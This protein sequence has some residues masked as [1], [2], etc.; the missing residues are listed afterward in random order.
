MEILSK[1]AENQL[2]GAYSA[3]TFGFRHKFTFFAQTVPDIADYLL[4][5]EKKLKS[6]LPAITE[7][8]ICSDIERALFARPVKFDSFGLR[9]LCEVAN[10]ELLNSKEI[11]RELYENVI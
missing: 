9:S 3:Y 10:I 4:T 11:I 1:L 6:R 8:H 7:R 5:I 2:R